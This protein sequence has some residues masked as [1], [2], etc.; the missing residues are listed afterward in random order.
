MSKND[1]QCNKEDKNF[2]KNEFLFDL[3]K[4]KYDSEL[5]RTSDID[6]KAH[7]SV[8]YVSV[9]VG[10]LL[11]SGSLLTGGAILKTTLFTEQPIQT[12]V[13]FG[14]IALLLLS[15]GFALHALKLRKWPSVP[16]VETLINTFK[17]MEHIAILQVI[18][19]SMKNAVTEIEQK[20][21]SKASHI[22][23]SSRLLIFGLI[24]VFGA[25]VNFSLDLPIFDINS[26]VF[27][28]PVFNANSIVGFLL[29]FN[30]NS[31][32]ES[33]GVWIPLAAGLIIGLI[34]IITSLSSR[35]R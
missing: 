33:L 9:I 23:T 21:D 2:K 15:I 10:L 1:C 35:Q 28:I 32:V 25:I 19:G 26:I 22:Q 18:G 30:V 20:N 8:G 14:G 17:D 34:Y 12:V 13:Y 4:R 11:G 6:G 27:F 16:N 24:L 3:I 7:N 5:A 29:V 31:T